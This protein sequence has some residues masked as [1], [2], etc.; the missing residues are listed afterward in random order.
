M[1]EAF[2]RWIEIQRSEPA[3][4]GVSVK[5]S[6]GTQGLNNNS[7]YADFRTNRFELTVQLWE[8]GESDLH[9][10][11]WE[12]PDKGVGVTHYVFTSENDMLSTIRLVIDKMH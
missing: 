4:A 9:I 5:V 8:T 11:D 6:T 2:R 1:I 10:L 12:N 3:L 7:I